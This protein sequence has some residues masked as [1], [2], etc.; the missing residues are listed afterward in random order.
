MSS[1]ARGSHGALASG[2]I[3]QRAQ[4]C[5]AT[6]Y[7]QTVVQLLSDSQSSVSIALVF[8][9]LLFSACKT[10]FQ[11]QSP[12]EGETYRSTAAT[13]ESTVHLQ[14]QSVSSEG[15]DTEVSSSPILV[16]VG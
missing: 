3:A 7:N 4:R 8:G 12:T 13:C 5:L 9:S 6:G 16:F 11:P 15:T 14:S 10:T 2:A 1:I